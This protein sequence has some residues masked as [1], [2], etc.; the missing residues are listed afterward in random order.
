MTRNSAPMTGYAL[1]LPLTRREPSRMLHIDSD[2]KTAILVA[3]FL[4]RH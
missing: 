4:Q 1:M 3:F 2:E